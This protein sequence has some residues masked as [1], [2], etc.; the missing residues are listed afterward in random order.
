M[1]S[2]EAQPQRRGARYWFSAWLPVLLGACVI[3]CESTVA[4]GADHTTGPLRHVWEWF[5]GP[6]ADDRWE[7]IHHLIR[8][9][10]HFIGYGLIGLAWLRAW[11]MTRPRGPFLQHASLAF[12][13]TALIASCDEFHQSFLPNRTGTPYDVLLDCTGATIL[14]CLTWLILRVS[15]PKRQVTTA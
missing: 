8:K 7:I 2:S 1:S 13:G 5:F 11:W 6:V 12:M 4:F 15:A 9:T 14:M 3:A 10:G